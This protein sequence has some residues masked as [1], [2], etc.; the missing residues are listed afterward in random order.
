M[1]E[2]VAVG[3][4]SAM[5]F[6]VRAESSTFSTFTMSFQPSL[7]DRTW[8]ATLTVASFSSFRILRTSSARPLPM[9]SMTVPLRIGVILSSRIGYPPLPGRPRMAL[10]RAIRT[11]TARNACRKYAAW[12]V[13]S[14]SGAISPARGSGCITISWGFASAS[15]RP[16][17]R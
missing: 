9:W 13:A 5:A 8:S 3:A 17:I 12:R 2:I 7:P 10:R 14:T 6:T 4:I 1:I 15:V 11:G 16:S